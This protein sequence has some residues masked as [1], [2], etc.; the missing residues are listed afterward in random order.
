MSY[1]SEGNPTFFASYL[2]S[3]VTPFGF[4][5]SCEPTDAAL[6]GGQLKLPTFW[7]DQLTNLVKVADSAHTQSDGK[8]SEPNRSTND[9]ANH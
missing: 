1:I 6:P 4:F 2:R 5:E 8:L 7:N 9:S 3:T